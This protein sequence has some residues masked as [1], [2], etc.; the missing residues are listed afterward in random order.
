MGI[1][2]SSWL[3]KFKVAQAGKLSGL[4]AKGIMRSFQLQKEQED[5][6]SRRLKPAATRIVLLKEPQ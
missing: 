3:I 4:K 2:D 5:V 1:A 6:G